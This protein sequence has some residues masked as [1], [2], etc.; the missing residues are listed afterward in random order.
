[1]VQVLCVTTEGALGGLRVG[2]RNGSGTQQVPEGRS[3]PQGFLTCPG[4]PHDMGIVGSLLQSSLP[5]GPPPRPH[6]APGA[7]PDSDEHPGLLPG[8]ADGRLS[9]HP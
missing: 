9:L 8:F 6:V 5:A 3:P 1:M 7:C 4:Q 2:L